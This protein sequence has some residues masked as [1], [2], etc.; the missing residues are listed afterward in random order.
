[1]IG[2]VSKNVLALYGGKPVRDK[3]LPI[4]H[5]GAS[6]IDDNEINAVVEVLKS[7]SLYRY[8]GPNFKGITEKF[9]TE[10]RKYIDAK[11]VLGVSS[12]TAALHTALTGLDVGPGDE[13]ILPAYAWVSCPNT[14]V[15][16]GATP[17][18]AN[19][20]ESLTLDPRD[21]E[22]KITNRTEA[23]MAVHMRGAPCNL[24]SLSRIAK[25]YQIMLLEDVAQATGGNYHGRKLGTIG[26]VSSYSFQLNKMISAGEGG[27][28]VTQDKTVYERAFIFHDIGAPYRR[29]NYL[30]KPFPGL[31][32]RMNEVTAAIMREQLKKIDD[33]VAKLRKNKAIIK[34]GISDIGRISFR[35]IHDPE[36]EVAVCLVFYV[37]DSKKAKE[38]KNALIAENIRTTSGGYPG[39]VYEPDRPDGHIFAYWS[40][41]IR[42]IDR[43]K[44]KYRQ[45][46]DI[47]G[48]AVHID[49]SPLLSDEDINDIIEALHK[50][51]NAIL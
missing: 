41:I 5:P 13:V 20:D 44:N 49:I 42:G 23:I 46:T 29:N 9:E 48:R 16:T 30:I 31:N 19:I 12:G 17:V 36:G 40:H 38:F 6:F 47:M 39:V 10:F 28:V 51:A 7:Q 22:S 3:P 24:D 34:R 18:L 21:V 11:Y 26:D 2:M 25:Q 14:I 1:M 35:T 15:A 8:Y 37:E 45:S 50:V 43:V 32:Y 27:A 33:V 4:M